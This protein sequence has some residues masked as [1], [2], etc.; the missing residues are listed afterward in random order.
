MLG[1]SVL[2]LEQDL[3]WVRVRAKPMLCSATFELTRW[4][5]SKPQIKS[6]MA[7]THE[8]DREK[9]VVFTWYSGVV[10]FQDLLASAQQLRDNQEFDSSFSQLMDMTGF[11]GTS[12]TFAELDGFAKFTDPFAPSAKRA[13]VAVND[14]AVGISRMYKSLRGN[15]SPFLLFSEVNAARHWLGLN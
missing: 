4:D 11:S 6:N 7:I 14:V 8:V 5:C 15:D 3:A 12:A 1:L 2:F 9:R 13:V 10:S